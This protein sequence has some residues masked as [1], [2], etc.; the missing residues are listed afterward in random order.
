MGLPLQVVYLLN[1]IF[2][3][4]TLYLFNTTIDRNLKKWLDDLSLPCK[5]ELPLFI[6]LAFLLNNFL[7]ANHQSQQLLQRKKKKKRIRIQKSCF[8]ILHISIPHKIHSQHKICQL[9]CESL[10]SSYGIPSLQ[11]RH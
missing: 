9:Q 3:F 6:F 8:L 10:L 1:T 7:K 11:Q 5:D 2:F 4:G